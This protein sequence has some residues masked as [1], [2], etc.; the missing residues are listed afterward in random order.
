MVKTMAKSKAQYWK[1]MVKRHSLWSVW[2]SPAIFAEDGRIIQ[3]LEAKKFYDFRTLLVKGI[4]GINPTAPE[5]NQYI[6]SDLVNGNKIYI[7]FI[8]QHGVE[9]IGYRIITRKEWEH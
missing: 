4:L 8:K 2:G 6:D 5:C 3:K 9:N 7:E 1:R